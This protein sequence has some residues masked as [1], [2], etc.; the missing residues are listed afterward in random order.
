M[1]RSLFFF[2]FIIPKIL[3]NTI[4]F[5]TP[6]LTYRIR[7][8]DILLDQNLNK[9]LKTTL[10]I[11]LWLNPFLLSL[12]LAASILGWT[13]IVIGVLMLN[14][15]TISVLVSVCGWMFRQSLNDYFQGKFIS[16]VGWESNG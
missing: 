1:Q 7:M 10:Q 16:W 9:R 8:I 12:Q 14:S 6:I 5:F 4:L 11:T 13:Q 3:E 15:I 2:P